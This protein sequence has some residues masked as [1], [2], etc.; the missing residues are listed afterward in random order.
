MPVNL[1]PGLVTE[2]TIGGTAENVIPANPNGGFI[3][4]PSTAA[5]PIYINPIDTATL[6]A[7]DKTFAIFPGQTWEV[8]AGQTTP[9]SVNAPDNNHPISAIYW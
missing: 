7:A 1:Q 6:T 4:N 2:I 3:T 5:L 9:T 8:I